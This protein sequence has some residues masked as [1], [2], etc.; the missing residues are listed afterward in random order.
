MGLSVSKAVQVVVG[1]VNDGPTITGR[2][3]LAAEEDT[4]I[5]VEG[6]RVNDP[7][8]DDAPRGVIE[9]SIAAS[10]GTVHFGGS[11]AGLYLMEAPPGTLQIRGKTGPVNAAL[12]GLDYTGAAEYSGEDTLLFI[13]DDLGYS[14][15]GGALRSNFSLHITIEAVN[16]PP[17][18][19]FP[20]EFNPSDVGVLFVMED[21]LTP[22]GRFGISD[23]DD[24]FVRVQVSTIFGRID[25]NEIDIFGP[26]KI[27]FN[28]S[29]PPRNGSS[30]TLEG[31]LEEVDKALANLTYTSPPNWNSVIEHKRDT[32]KVRP[33]TQVN[34]CI[35]SFLRASRSRGA[36][37]SVFEG[38]SSDLIGRAR[39]PYNF[40]AA[41][42]SS[43]HLTVPL[44]RLFPICGD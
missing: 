26:L 20:T 32:V 44:S 24:D 17:L 18:I 8:C 16:D 27:V 34:R 1:A 3:H 7:D 23:P 35:T 21:Q 5:A 14:G 33:H 39:E 9:V 43:Q 4:T 6:I 38:A 30:V 19:S 42:F 22:L 13:V 31:A 25:A 37:A 2:H 40:S 10:N 36:V 12:A 15:M 41:S 28:T 11:V 29:E